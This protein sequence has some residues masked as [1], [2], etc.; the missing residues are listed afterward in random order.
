LSLVLWNDGHDLAAH[1]FV[2][3]LSFGGGFKEA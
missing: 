3:A 2:D 1:G